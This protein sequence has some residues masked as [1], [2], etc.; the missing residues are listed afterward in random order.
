M[1][2]SPPVLR[3]DIFYSPCYANS[4]SPVHSNRTF[5]LKRSPPLATGFRLGGNAPMKTRQKPTAS[6]A[7][8]VC[9]DRH[10]GQQSAPVMLRSRVGR[11]SGVDLSIIGK[12]G[13]SKKR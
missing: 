5:A 2:H 6:R 11:V 3:P 8:H 12:H 10:C 1:G 9:R 7:D 13:G 4:A